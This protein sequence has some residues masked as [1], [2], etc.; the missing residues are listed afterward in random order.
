MKPISPMEMESMNLNLTGL[1][2]IFIGFTANYFS[3]RPRSFKQ[4]QH[5]G[6][7]LQPY[8]IIVGKHQLK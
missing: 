5:R 1:S 8:F 3:T 4:K 7:H 2:I 6:L